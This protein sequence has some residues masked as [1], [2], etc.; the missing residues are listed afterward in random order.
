MDYDKV[1]V[2]DEGKVVEYLLLVLT[3]ANSDLIPRSSFW[4]GKGFS[5]GWLGRVVS[6]MHYIRLRKMENKYRDLVFAIEISLI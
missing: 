2:L 6:M 5:M 3:M 4:K 1:L